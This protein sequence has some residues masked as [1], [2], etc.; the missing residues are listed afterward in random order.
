MCIDFR[1]SFRSEHLIK[2]KKKLL[3]LTNIKMNLK[4]F[5]ADTKPYMKAKEYNIGTEA[6]SRRN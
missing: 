4:I 3:A 1:N 2:G 6:R 5:D